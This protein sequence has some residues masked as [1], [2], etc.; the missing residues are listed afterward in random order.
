MTSLIAACIQLCSSDQI[1]ENIVAASDWIRLAAKQ[2]ANLIVTPEMTH[3]MDQRPGQLLIKAQCEA[4]D[5]A[6]KAFQHLAAE[7]GVHLLIGSL[8][9]KISDTHCV[10]R[11]YCLGPTGAIVAY[12]DKIHLFDVQLSAAQIYRE[13]ER[14]QAGKQ[15][16]MVSTAQ[17]KLGLTICYDLRF[18]ALYRYLAQQG[19][20]II[21]VPAAFTQITGEAHWHVLLRARAIETGCFILAA[22]Q[23]G[24]HADGRQTYG[25]SLI[26][27]PWGKILAEKPNGPGV[28]IAEL[29]LNRVQ[30]VR[31]QIP[32]WKQGWGDKRAE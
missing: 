3:L 23:Q 1:A 12:Y 10:N 24:Q 11:S 22:A 20:D 27:D 28:I 30:Q 4:E 5:V 15:P 29:D 32:S 13:S 17:A 21:T 16:V 9:M 6:L 2:G 26:V 19:A 31:Q 18:A 14:F 7:L 8:A 25:H